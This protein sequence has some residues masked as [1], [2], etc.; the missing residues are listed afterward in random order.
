MW[1]AEG[2][3]MSG[4][5]SIVDGCLD[6]QITHTASFVVNN[7]HTSSPNHSIIYKDQSVVHSGI[8]LA[9]LVFD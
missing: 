3:R 6:Y 9:Q 4:S 2:P 1:K 5:K 7:V 8:G